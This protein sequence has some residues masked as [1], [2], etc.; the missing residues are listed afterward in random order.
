MEKTIK[1]KSKYPPESAGRRMIEN[2]PIVQPEETILNIKKRLFKEIGNLETINYV[3]VVEKSGKLV[4]VFSIKEIFRRPENTK[5]KEI[6]KTKLITA[7]PYTD[8]E[9][10]AIFALK[11]NLKSIPVVD[12]DEKFLGVVP[13]DI[14]LDILHFEHVE[15][16][17]KLGGISKIVDTLP[18]SLIKTPIRTLTE[19][20]LPWLILGLFGGILA[21]QIISF[22]ESSLKTHFI[23]AAFIPLIVYM[24]DAVG[25][26]TQT[27]TVRNL[28]FESQ[29]SFK[30]YLL[31][32]IKISLLIGLVL[33][34]LLSLISIFWHNQPP[35]IGLILGISLFLTVV[36]AIFIGFLIPYALQKFKKDPAIGSGPFATIITDVA[37]LAIYFSVGSI[38]L[39]FFE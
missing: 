28:A 5:I 36:S 11:N 9:R 31:K 16:I 8:Q 18:D 38:L 24:A 2:V 12:K 37:S 21:A 7:R 26:Q 32:E 39:K 34:V 6:M 25:T 17:L 1:D 13:S 35:Y 14:I 4:G 10:V 30:K 27:L 29:I 22:F 20:R 3:Y 15:D 23:L 33:G 19:A